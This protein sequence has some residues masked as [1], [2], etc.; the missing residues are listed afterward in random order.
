MGTTQAQVSLDLKAYHG[1]PA[2]EHGNQALLK[3]V[4][5][6]R[7]L[8][9][10]YKPHSFQRAQRETVLQA[11][12]IIE[13]YSDKGFDL[14]LRQLYYQFVS[15]GLLDN[16]DGNYNRLGNIVVDGRMSGVIPWDK[17]KDRSRTLRGVEHQDS[18]AEAIQDLAE[19]YRIDKWRT[20]NHR[21]EVWV[22]KDA[23]IGV[24][25]NACV[26][27]DID[28][29]AAHG[30]DSVTMLWQA[31]QHRFVPYVSTGQPVTILHL[32]D[33]DPSGIDMTRD[34]KDRLQ[35]F[36][37]GRMKNL[38]IKRIAL[39]WEQVERY[40]PPAN[41]IK[42]PTEDSQGESRAAAYRERF[43]TDECWELDALDPE[44]IV[45]LIQSEIQNYIEPDLWDSA[46][47]RED[48]ERRQLR[49]VASTWGQ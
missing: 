13:E 32:A 48:D 22:E 34:I 35:V 38:E 2:S 31:A 28:F 40:Q 46:V 11:A 29:Y 23:L 3:E 49:D 17:I 45:D 10:C 1:K 27:Y 4:A 12:N 19:S 5:G 33:H 14:T 44:I 25:G 8:R 20:Q 47:E 36:M 18:P 21:V 37:G 24:L 39:N 26:P 43:G 16:T 30:F 42:E 6:L 7:G 15:R 41:K 9:I